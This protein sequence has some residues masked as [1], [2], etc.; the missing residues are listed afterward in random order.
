MTKKARLT[1]RAPRTLTYADY[2]PEVS[3]MPSVDNIAKGVDAFST[4]IGYFNQVRLKKHHPKED[5]GV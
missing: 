5:W 1:G 3:V 4:N 2:T